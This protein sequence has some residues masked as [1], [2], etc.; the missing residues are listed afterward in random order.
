VVLARRVRATGP[1]LAGVSEPSQAV[2]RHVPR[3]LTKTDLAYGQIRQAILEGLFRPGSTL[4]QE[5]LAEQLDLST[6][7]VREALRRLESER[8]VVRRAHRDTVVAP[9]SMTTVEESFAVRF[10]LDPMAASLAATK[11]TPEE[12]KLLKELLVADEPGPRPADR[13]TRH[14]QLHRAVYGACHNELLVEMLDTLWDVGDRYRLV[15]L[16]H[17]AVAPPLPKD[18]GPI[19][20]AVIDGKAKLAAKLM[21]EHTAEAFQTISDSAR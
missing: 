2:F 3:A 4:D 14:R 11:A 12:R 15:A 5:V 7:P 13:V 9:L 17:G 18:H 10:A 1:G 20:E 19:L 8:L 21:H 16:Q 6:T